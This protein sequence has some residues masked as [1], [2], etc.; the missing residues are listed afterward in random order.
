MPQRPTDNAIRDQSIQSSR[1]QRVI[2]GFGIGDCSPN[3]FSLMD[4]GLIPNL[5]RHR[6]REGVIVSPQTI[7]DKVRHRDA[8]FQQYGQHHPAFKQLVVD[9]QP[10]NIGSYRLVDCVATLVKCDAQHGG[11]TV[12][13]FNCIGPMPQ[14]RPLQRRRIQSQ[15]PHMVPDVAKRLPDGAFLEPGFINEY[16]APVGLRAQRR[17]NGLNGRCGSG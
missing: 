10:Q 3:S 6:C 2:L 1:N 13:E 5:L 9:S 8:V 4:P 14:R 15:V 16:I 17:D 12:Y 11:L 7:A